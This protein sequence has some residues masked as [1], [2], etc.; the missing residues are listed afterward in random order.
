MQGGQC[1]QG[2]FVRVDGP[3]PIWLPFGKHS[4]DDISFPLR[5]VFDAHGIGFVHAEATTP[6]SSPGR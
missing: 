2:K 5:P 3:S 6:T 4:A 1:R